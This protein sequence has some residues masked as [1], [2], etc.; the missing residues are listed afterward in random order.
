MTRLRDYAHWLAKEPESSP[1]HL[2]CFLRYMVSKLTVCVIGSHRLF[3]KPVKDHV[4]LTGLDLHVILVGV[5]MAM[6][7]RDVTVSRHQSGLID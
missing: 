4:T 6:L 5:A 1:I 7:L 2:Q 3:F